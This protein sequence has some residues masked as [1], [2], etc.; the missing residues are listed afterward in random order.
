M[1]DSPERE[2]IDMWLYRPVEAI[3]K[4]LADRALKA[5]LSFVH[6]W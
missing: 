3:E 2:E 1:N 6:C 5:G 4:L